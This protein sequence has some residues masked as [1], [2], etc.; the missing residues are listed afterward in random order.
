[1]RKENILGVPNTREPGPADISAMGEEI[2]EVLG[3]GQLAQVGGASNTTLQK[4]GGGHDDGR[5][6]IG[7]EIF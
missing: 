3:L 4:C 5:L 1:M 2:D 7:G 6:K